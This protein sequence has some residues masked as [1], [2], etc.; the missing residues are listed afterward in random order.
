MVNSSMRFKNF[1]TMFIFFLFFS[2]LQYRETAW[3]LA[4]LLNAESLHLIPKTVLVLPEETSIK[5]KWILLP[6][7][8][9][10]PPNI[11]SENIQF[12]IDSQNKPLI[13][14]GN[15]IL[16]NPLIN[17]YIVKIKQ[18]VKDMI[19]LDNGV[20]LLSD[21]KS[22]GYLEVE[23]KNSDIVPVAT[24]NPVVKLPFTNP[25]VYNGDD[26]IYAVAYNSKTKKY[27]V[28]LFNPMKKA[29]EKIV[30]LNKRVSSV[31]GIK[32]HLFF[33]IDRQIKEYK[34]G[35]FNTVYEHPRESIEKVFY[36][37]KAGLFYKTEHGLGF[38][39]DG[40]A[41]EFV[42]SEN[43]EVFLKGTSIY[44]FFAKALAIAEFANIDDLK[45]YNFKVKKIIDINRTF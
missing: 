16:F 23:K 41:L 14:Y 39:K 19:C 30:S 22:L 37:E 40:T 27:E 35:K 38:V 2:G 34:N 15:R 9:D 10:N 29:F 24:I 11:S 1:L 44:V 42:Q 7:Q 4:G 12:V 36:S 26:S 32:G 13:V 31:S 8:K 43:F 6:G 21:G 33:S 3:H 18:T 5:I 17:A 20:L 45:N 28:Y 25:R